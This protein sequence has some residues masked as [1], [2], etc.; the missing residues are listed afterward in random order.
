MEMEATFGRLR[1]EIRGC[2]VDLQSHLTFPFAVIPLVP[3]V[4]RSV[5]AGLDLGD[6]VAEEGVFALFVTL[7]WRELRPVRSAGPP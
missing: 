1:F 2:I 6:D 7:F 4:W 3:E 5:A